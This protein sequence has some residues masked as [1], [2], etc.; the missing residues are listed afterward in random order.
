MNKLFLTNFLICLLDYNFLTLVVKI[1][2]IILLKTKLELLLNSQDFN[3][4]DNILDINNK[5]IKLYLIYKYYIHYIFT[6][7]ELDIFLL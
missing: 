1:I 3:L 5:K 4:L 6:F 2:S 7:Q